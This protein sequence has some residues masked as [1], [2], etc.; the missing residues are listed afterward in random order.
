M[1][2]S[3]VPKDSDKPF[4]YIGDSYQ[5]AQSNL[6]QTGFLTPV[7]TAGNISLSKIKS[8]SNVRL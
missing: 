4:V 2:Y 6:T 7:I 8:S 3:I 5:M 1:L